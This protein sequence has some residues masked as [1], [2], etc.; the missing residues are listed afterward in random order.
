[1]PVLMVWIQHIVGG[2]KG[3]Y[4]VTGG[5]SLL[6]GLGACVVLELICQFNV[7]T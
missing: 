3:E 6:I 5:R 1:M 2:L 4:E 7:I